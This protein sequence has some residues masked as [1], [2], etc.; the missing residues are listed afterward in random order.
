MGLVFEAVDDECLEENDSSGLG[1]LQLS[2][3]FCRRVFVEQSDGVLVVQPYAE[4]VLESFDRKNG[5]DEE[6]AEKDNNSDNDGNL[7]TENDAL[8]Y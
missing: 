2:P 5:D 7:Q 3:T 4:W 8:D 6:D 1:P